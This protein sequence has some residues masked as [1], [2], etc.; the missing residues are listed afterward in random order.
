MYPRDA[1]LI[2]EWFVARENVAMGDAKQRF[3]AVVREVDERDG[4]EGSFIDVD[5][6]VDGEGRKYVVLAW[7]KWTNL[8]Q[9]QGQGEGMVNGVGSDDGA[10]AKAE[11]AQRLWTSPDALPKGSHVELVR[12][13][14]SKLKEMKAKWI[15]EE[16]DC[17]MFTLLRASHPRIHP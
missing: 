15:D 3:W 6:E 5:A 1:T 10:A 16:K 4:D 8:V 2:E 14:K 7:A 11:E 13:F 12:A 17:G 9:G